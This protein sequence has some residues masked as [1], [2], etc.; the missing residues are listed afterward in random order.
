[1]LLEPQ[2][3]FRRK[4]SKDGAG[5]GDPDVLAR[6]IT[7]YIDVGAF[8]GSLSIPGSSDVHPLVVDREGTILARGCGDPDDT[9]WP[10][11][12]AGLLVA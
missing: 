2:L 10:A 7:V 5:I 11:I 4:R 3:W 8:Q 6:T 9:S 1:M 12:A